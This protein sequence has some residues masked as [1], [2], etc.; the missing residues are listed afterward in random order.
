MMAQMPAE[1]A[2]Y[3]QAN[4]AREVVLEPELVGEH[5]KLEAL[6]K[7]HCRDGLAVRRKQWPLAM[8]DVRLAVVDE[9]DGELQIRVHAHA[10]YDPR[11]EH[12]R[13]LPWQA[14]GCWR[15]EGPLGLNP[16]TGPKGPL[17][18]N[19][20]KHATTSVT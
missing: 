4:A 8:Q 1:R 19:P 10:A 16:H 18:Q 9:P 15:G 5:V 13:L 11:A 3:S 17:G 20:R 2:N 12:A 6:L 7:G 14:A